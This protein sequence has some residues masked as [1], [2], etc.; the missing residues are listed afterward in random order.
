MSRRSK[1]QSKAAHRRNARQVLRS[2]VPGD[3]I[4]LGVWHGVYRA[5]VASGEAGWR[6]FRGWHPERSWPQK[7]L[8][9]AV[10]LIIGVLASAPGAGPLVLNL[11]GLRQKVGEAIE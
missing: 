4:A 1:Q 6:M 8:N 10:G 9:E 7:T 3:V 2:A 5:R 11:R